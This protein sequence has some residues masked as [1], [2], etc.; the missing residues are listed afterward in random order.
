M[1]TMRKSAGDCPCFRISAGDTNYFVLLAD[2]AAD[3]VAFVT[4]VEI[5]EPGGKTPPNA[6]VAAWEQFVI[7]AGEG[8][9]T[10]DGRTDKITAGDILVVPPGTEH[11]IENTGAGKLYCLTTMMPDEG[12][13][14]LIRNGIPVPLGD[15]D[16]RVLSERLNASA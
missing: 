13:S 14:A 8:L 15:D 11:V 7:L 2:P 9:A 10:A 16:R 6:H 4:V 5:F 12:F 3:A 1:P